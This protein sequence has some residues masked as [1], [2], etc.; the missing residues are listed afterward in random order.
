MKTI[1]IKGDL[2]EGLGRSATKALRKEGKVP[3]V[4]YGKNEPVHFGVYEI[5]FKNLVYTPNSYAVLLDVNNQKTLAKLQ[6][7]QFDP[8]SEAIMHADF[9]EIDPKKPVQMLIP[10]KITGNSP[11]VIAGGKLQVKIKKLKAFGLI[12]DM[13]EFIEVKVDKLQLGKSIR[14]KEVSYENLSFLDAEGNSIVGCFQ[15]RASRTGDGEA[16]DETTEESTEASEE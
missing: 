6:D 11:G 3:C 1:A 12:T 16:E 13:P 7:I 15:T 2:R 8:V 5:D 4:L 14:V 10:V 9:L